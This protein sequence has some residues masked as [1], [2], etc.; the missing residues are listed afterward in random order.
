MESDL[1]K[2]NALY[3]FSEAHLISEYTVVLVV[4]TEGE[5]VNAFKLV[6][7]HSVVVFVNS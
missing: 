1:Y 6:V 3:C 5:P 2:S 4:V 7:S